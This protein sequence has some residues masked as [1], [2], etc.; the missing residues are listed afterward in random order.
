M[1]WHSKWH[2]IKHRKAAQ[3]AKKSKVYA[4][5]AKVIQ[6]AARNGD[7]PSLNPSLDNALTKARQAGL[8]KDVIQKAI[9][10]GA[11]N[12]E[13]EELQEIFY[14][15]YGPNGVALYIKCVTTNTNR[16]SSV[17]RSTLTKYGWNLGEPG[18]VSWQFN[19]K[20]EI[21][22]NGTL[23]TEQVKWKEIEKIIPLNEEVFEL[24]VL[25]TPAEDYEIIDNDNEQVARVVTSRDDF[26]ATVKALELHDRNIEQSDLQFL[27]ENEI[28]LD[29]AGEQKLERL[30]EALEEDDDVDTVW[31]NAAG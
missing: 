22:V 3:D 8:P 27:A 25:E 17:V 11:G 9:D 10:K 24:A 31:H 6:M 7:D 12:I 5:V 18:S 29:E 13:G 21:F 28:E 1:A 19:E 26:M 15:W 20:G 4:K 23:K 2:N 30:I 16:T 14:E